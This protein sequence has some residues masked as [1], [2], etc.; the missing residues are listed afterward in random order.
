MNELSNT[1]WYLI[2]VQ[3]LQSQIFL[4]FSER[5][6]VDL[7]VQAVN[8]VSQYSIVNTD[9][10][11]STFSDLTYLSTLYLAHVLKVSQ[12]NLMVI[13]KGK[14]N[15]ASWNHWFEKKTTFQSPR[16]NFERPFDVRRA[17]ETTT[18]FSKITLSVFSEYDMGTYSV[19]NLIVP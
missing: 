11:Q 5:I 7:Q 13:S 18:S 8:T 9:W 3:Q 14:E 17:F 19:R 15:R 2:F 6:K 1:F 12:V 16:G 10:C 4:T